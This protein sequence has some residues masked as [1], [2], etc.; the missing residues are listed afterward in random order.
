MYTDRGPNC[1]TVTR[2]APK[3]ARLYYKRNSFDDQ[4][5]DVIVTFQR[6]DAVLVAVDLKNKHSKR[7][8]NDAVLAT[9]GG[10]VLVTE[11][12]QRRVRELSRRRFYKHP[13]VYN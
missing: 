7:N 2:G 6:Y 5:P 1:D 8:G 3:I 9:M 4:I 10:G 13:H 12:P 11:L